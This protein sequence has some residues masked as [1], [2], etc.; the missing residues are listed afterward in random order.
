M[1]PLNNI[2]HQKIKQVKIESLS[3][4]K[5][6]CS[7]LKSVKKKNNLCNPIPKKKAHKTCWL[8]NKVKLKTL[9]KS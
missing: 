9:R 4:R 6:R 2:M 3:S 8:R 7:T 5:F 1:I